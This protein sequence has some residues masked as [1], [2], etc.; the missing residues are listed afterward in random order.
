MSESLPL[1]S[2]QRRGSQIH[3]AQIVAAILS[4]KKKTLRSCAQLTKICRS[5]ARA[6]SLHKKSRSSVTDCI[7][8]ESSFANLSVEELRAKLKEA[9][10]RSFNNRHQLQ[11]A[12]E[13]GQQLLAEETELEARLAGCKSSLEATEEAE[14][15][16][17][18]ELPSS[19][20]GHH[21][22][23]HL[24]A[25]ACGKRIY[26]QILQHH[27]EGEWLRE[28]IITMEKELEDNVKLMEQHKHMDEVHHLAANQNWTAALG[29]GEA[30][31]SA[32]TGAWAA[33]REKSAGELAAVG[34]MSETMLQR[35]HLLNEEVVES[36]AKAK[37]AAETR[38]RERVEMEREMIATRHQGNIMLASLRKELQVTQERNAQLRNDL[39]MQK[40]VR[41]DRVEAS[42]TSIGH[43][44]RELDDTEHGAEAAETEICDMRSEMASAAIDH[45]VVT[46]RVELQLPL[47]AGS[48]TA[49]EED[50]EAESE[51]WEGAL[52]KI[53]SE[54]RH[55][56]LSADAFSRAQHE[57]AS[58]GFGHVQTAP[59]SFKNAL[60]KQR[61][62]KPGKTHHVYKDVEV[63]VH[64]A[65]EEQHKKSKED[66][67]EKDKPRKKRMDLKPREAEDDTWGSGAAW[68][69]WSASNMMGDV[70]LKIDE[71]TRNADGAP[72]VNS[73]ATAATGKAGKKA[74]ERRF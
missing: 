51:Y 15:M 20:H 13:R 12:G 45:Q 7:P 2:F 33:L 8:E 14:A 40:Q 6:D 5:M 49:S 73:T 44:Q 48:T 59:A 22:D 25:S 31:S 60:R 38:A 11:I 37:H 19:I 58:L 70:L 23:L 39:A 9:E 47:P 36:T 56:T 50:S 4:P 42:L 68:A 43:L 66:K 65:T 34:K 54:R 41:I 63:V 52:H 30:K 32:G 21:G 29:I 64:T 3:R 61:R 57:R 71:M 67:E 10:D 17:E 62:Q 69:A 53:E 1:A 55:A 74:K 16:A 27:T 18:K 24:P 28:Q 35:V 26:R 46:K 72:G